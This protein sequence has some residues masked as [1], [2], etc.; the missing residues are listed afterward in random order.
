MEGHPSLLHLITK[1]VAGARE[2]LTK[3]G[4]QESGVALSL[5]RFF[6]LASKTS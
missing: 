5:L 1:L 3:S 6:N 4:K 2:K